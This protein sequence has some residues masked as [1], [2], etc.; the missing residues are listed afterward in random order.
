MKKESKIT[1]GYSNDRGFRHVWSPD[2]DRGLG[3]Q[4]CYVCERRFAQIEFI[5]RAKTILSEEISD[6]IEKFE[7]DNNVQVSDISME[8]ENL[9]SRKIMTRIEIKH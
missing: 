1:I 3:C 5:R 4:C 9:G 6:L 2:G 8:I 7:K